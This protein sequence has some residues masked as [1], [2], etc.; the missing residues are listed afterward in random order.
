MAMNDYID[1]IRKAWAISDLNEIVEAAANDDSLTTEEYCK[2]YE[3]AIN[4]VR[5]GKDNED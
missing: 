5:E 1:R 4:D 2:I 3:T